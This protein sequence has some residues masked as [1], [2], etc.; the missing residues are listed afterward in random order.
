L[1][2]EANPT[3]R[4]KSKASPE[5]EDDIVDIPTVRVQKNATK[6]IVQ[7]PTH[8]NASINAPQNS[9]TTLF[10]EPTQEISEAELVR[11][12]NQV[13][14]TLESRLRNEKMRRGMW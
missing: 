8:Q 3:A 6:E 13:Y 14:H 9:K 7:Q 11:I 2:E 5:T 4:P 1:R 12:T 10:T